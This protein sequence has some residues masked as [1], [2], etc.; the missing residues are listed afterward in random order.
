MDE[1]PPIAELLQRVMS[2][3]RGADQLRKWLA[4]VALT[5]CV[6]A[7]LLPLAIPESHHESHSETLNVDFSPSVGL[8]LGGIAL[9]FGLVVFV[10]PVVIFTLLAIR[11]RRNGPPARV[12][13]GVLGLLGTVC[14]ALLAVVRMNRTVAGA[15]AVG[16][17][18]VLGLGLLALSI[19]SRGAETEA[20]V[21]LGDVAAFP[22]NRTRSWSAVAA[23]LGAVLVFAGL[24][25]QSR[26]DERAEARTDGRSPSL[27]LGLTEPPPA[28]SVNRGR[29][30]VR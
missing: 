4:T 20:A 12:A 29:S 18:L 1:P 11:A 3:A 6:C 7:W 9:V 22:G 8:F 15:F 17:L 19:L 25:Q 27:S 10:A 16:V 30:S 28:P 13:A 5:L 24:V 2:D 14:A 21:A 23:G 26:V